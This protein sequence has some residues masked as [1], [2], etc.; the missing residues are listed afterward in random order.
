YGPM[1]KI[2]DDDFTFPLG[3]GGIYAPIGISGGSG[4]ATS[5][6]FTAIYYRNNPQ[7]VISNIVESG[8]DHIS[9]VE[10]WDLIKNSGNASKIVTLDVHETSFAKLLNKTYV[11]RYDTT[12]WL[13]LSSTPGTSSSCGI[14]E[15]GKTE[16][17]TATYNYGHFTFWTDQTFAMNPL[18]IKLIDFTVTKISSGVAAI[19]WELAECCA[20]DA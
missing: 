19:H 10:Y 7:N 6:E 1:K 8:I 11:T 16:I 5:D 20:A 13:K 12:K 4:S 15:C 9:Y 3:D 18:P 2:G 14:Y 17:N